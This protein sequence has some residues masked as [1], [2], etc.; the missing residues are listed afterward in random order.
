MMNVQTTP[1]SAQTGVIYSQQ[2]L[3]TIEQFCKTE[4]AFTPGGLR[5]L[6]FTRGHDLPGVYRFGRKILIDPTEFVAGVKAG[7]TAHIAGAK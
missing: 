2:A 3:Q 5:H 1:T 4:R 7:S 6:F